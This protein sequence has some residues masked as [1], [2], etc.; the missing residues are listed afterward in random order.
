MLAFA[1]Q[2]PLAAICSRVTGFWRIVVM[3]VFTAIAY[4]GAFNVWRGLWNL[5][6]IYLLPGAPLSRNRLQRPPFAQSILSSLSLKILFFLSHVQ[7][8]KSGAIC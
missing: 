6:D 3:D 4:V 7:I 1:L 5:Y 8:I 2:A